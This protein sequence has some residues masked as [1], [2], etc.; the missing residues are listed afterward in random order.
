ELGGGFPALGRDA[1]P[2]LGAAAAL[3]RRI[4][5]PGLDQALV[6]QAIERGV[7]RSNGAGFFRRL[8][9]FFADR[10]A[11]SLVAQ[12]GGGGKKEIFELTQ[13]DSY[14]IVI[15]MRPRSQVMR[16]LLRPDELPQGHA[17]VT[18]KS[19]IGRARGRCLLA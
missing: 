19:A 14:H 12:P 17:E 13:A 3:R 5:H 9:H 15:L 18:P 4:A 1:Y 6:L 2:P 7:E 16:W 10:S 11:I 8:L